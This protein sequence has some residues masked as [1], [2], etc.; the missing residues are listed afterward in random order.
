MG[1]GI[2]AFS[3]FFRDKN[4]Q[5]HFYFQNN[6]ILSQNLLQIASENLKLLKLRKV[7]LFL[8]FS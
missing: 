7:F 8:R 3:R 2:F 4:L 1:G 5:K 6:L